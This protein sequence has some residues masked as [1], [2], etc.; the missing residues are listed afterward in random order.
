MA[1]AHRH[2]DTETPLWQAHTDT[3][4]PKHRYAQR[5]SVSGVTGA[6]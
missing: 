2:L 3:S 6:D 4:T 1:G 5:A